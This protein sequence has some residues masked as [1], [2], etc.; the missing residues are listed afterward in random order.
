MALRPLRWVVTFS[1]PAAVAVVL[2]AVASCK[3]ASEPP[4]S[5]TR[6]EL[7]G[8]IRDALTGGFVSNATVQAMDA[9]ASTNARGEFTLLLPATESTELRVTKDGY[10][11][12]HRSVTVVPG[13]QR[14][15]TLHLRA[16]DTTLPLDATAG[17][18]ASTQGATV[19]V[20]A[21]DL[22]ASG[23]VNVSIAAINPSSSDQL[24]SLPGDLSVTVGGVPKALA[25]FGAIAVE[26]RDASGA[27]VP[28]APGRTVRLS[29]PASLPAG[30]STLPPV[31]DVYSFDETVRAWV[32]D[33]R[34]TLSGN[35]YELTVS[36]LS[37]FGAFDLK[38][39]TCID[40]CVSDSA[41]KPVPNAN[42]CSRGIGHF[43]TSVA[44]TNGDGCACLDVAANAS[45]NV[46]MHHASGMQTKPV[47]TLAPTNNCIL[48]GPCQQ[49]GFTVG[50]PDAGTRADAGSAPDAGS[51]SGYNGMYMGTATLTVTTIG[52][53]CTE[54]NPISL[55][56]NG[57]AATGT[58]G[59]GMTVSGT[60]A[61]T[62]SFSGSGTGSGCGG[63]GTIPLS[64]SINA[65]G[66]FTASGS[67]QQG[68]GCCGPGGADI[69]L[70]FTATKH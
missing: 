69:G 17:G 39:S 67:T 6:I 52:G 13:Y 60:V 70:S 36:H 42:V 56:V 37:I 10:A 54:P 68:G 43:R 24:D 11:P 25:A 41:G 19:T 9:N 5:E 14:T 62:G 28:V 65:S 53:T 20:G 58:V 50:S 18:T 38:E 47:G 49:L 63:S 2:S 40:V 66:G 26:V 48:G 44:V 33:G 23:T 30:M 35:N 3:P 32:A 22:A 21:N 15:L 27:H 59:T 29:I 12:L 7:V 4:P 61:G 31:I 34:A 45:V 55:T 64:G 46:E 16:F 1:G 51:G 8:V 57:S